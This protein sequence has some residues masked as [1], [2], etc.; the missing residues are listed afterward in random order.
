MSKLMMLTATA[1]VVLAGCSAP[2]GTANTGDKREATEHTKVARIDSAKLDA[3][4][5]D[6][7]REKDRARD[8]YR[9]TAKTMAFFDLSPSDNLVEVLPGGGWYTRVLLPYVSPDGGW[10]GINYS[11]DLRTGIFNAADRV[12]SDDALAE[13]KQ[14]PQ[15]YPETAKRNGPENA[16]IKGAFLF[17]MVPDQDKGTMDG[18]FFIR[19]IHHLNRID[20]KFFEES[21]ANSYALL[22]PGGIVGVVQHRAREDYGDVDYDTTG[23]KGYMKQSYVIDMFEKGGF[24]LDEASEINANPKDTADYEG[25]VW[26]L[27]PSLRGKDETKRED[28]VAIGESDRMTLRFRKPS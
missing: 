20:P 11:P 18:V 14:W 12:I 21:I 2:Q 10:Y 13:Y 17:S 1:L 15:K 22:K 6:P 4:L 5:A 23:N 9:H 19:A 24:V 3:V 27:P 16:A 28:Y 7:R 8:V 26:T 25:G